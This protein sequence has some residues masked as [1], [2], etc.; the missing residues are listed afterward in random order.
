M[1]LIRLDLRWHG[2]CFLTGT[3]TELQNLDFRNFSALRELTLLRDMT[4]FDTGLIPRLLAPKLQT[5][6]GVWSSDGERFDDELSESNRV[7][8]FGKRDTDWLVALGRAA[9]DFGVPLRHVRVCLKLRHVFVF[10]RDLAGK[11]NFS[12]LRYPCDLI[13][14]AN[15]ELR[16]NETWIEWV[17]PDYSK[18]DFDDRKTTLV[19]WNNPEQVRLRKEESERWSQEMCERWNQEE[20]EYWANIRLRRTNTASVT[21]NEDDVSV[22]NAS[23]DGDED[24]H[25]ETASG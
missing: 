10:L 20:T 9:R 18:E 7:I 1:T 13:S 4:G 6:T 2:Q 8:Y 25:E 3:G 21:Q 24:V 19:I 15:Q 22:Q 5:F 16:P 23:E 17:D 11:S 14:E 12:W